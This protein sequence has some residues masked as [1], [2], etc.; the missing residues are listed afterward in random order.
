M[1]RATTTDCTPKGYRTPKTIPDQ[2]VLEKL[3]RVKDLLVRYGMKR[4]AF[5]GM[6][7]TQW[8]KFPQPDMVLT[9]QHIMWWEST[10]AAWESTRPNVR[11]A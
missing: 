6:R 2:P 11:K 10:I 7:S 9:R 8:A 5:D 4:D 1:D 3:Y